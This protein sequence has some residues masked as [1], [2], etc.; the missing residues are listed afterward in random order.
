MF[1]VAKDV[2]TNFKY[3]RALQMEEGKLDWRKLR[4]TS[5]PFLL[6]FTFYQEKTEMVFSTI[7][8]TLFLLSDLL[9]AERLVTVVFG[10]ECS[11]KEPSK[12]DERM[13]ERSSLFKG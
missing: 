8:E 1:L 11:S 3:I 6:P 9:Q 13:G 4:W 12:K 10:V 2:N 5:V 7:S